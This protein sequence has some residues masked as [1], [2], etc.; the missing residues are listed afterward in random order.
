MLDVWES[1]V[2]RDGFLTSNILLHIYPGKQYT[3]SLLNN[4]RCIRS[5][6]LFQWTQRT[7]CW[8]LLAWWR[9]K[10]IRRGSPKWRHVPSKRKER[11][12]NKCNKCNNYHNSRS[13]GRTDSTWGSQDFT[14]E[15]A[16]SWGKGSSCG[17]GEKNGSMEC[18]LSCVGFYSSVHSSNAGV[19]R[20]SLEGPHHFRFWIPC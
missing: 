2:K 19:L 20:S 12:T 5:H 1:R 8:V 13:G 17:A 15:G 18:V 3:C 10:K 11:K 14:A 4:N 7:L 16:S 6:S 9:Y